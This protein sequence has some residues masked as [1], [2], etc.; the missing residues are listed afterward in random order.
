MLGG[1]P[2]WVGH[3]PEGST[4][5]TALF[6]LHLF[7]SCFNL[8]A[9]FLFFSMFQNPLYVIVQ[10]ISFSQLFLHLIHIFEES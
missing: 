7:K 3:C 5:V 9:V 4:A 1:P 2:A 10:F 6:P 8:D